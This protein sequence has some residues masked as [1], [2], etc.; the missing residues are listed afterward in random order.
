M[1]ITPDKLFIPK[2]IP[3]IFAANAALPLPALK[4]NS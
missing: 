3:L 4:S 1:F 2:L